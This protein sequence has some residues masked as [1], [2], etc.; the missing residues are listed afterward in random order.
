MLTF[1]KGMG[2]GPF[3]ERM[4]LGIGTLLRGGLEKRV[5]KDGVAGILGSRRGSHQDAAD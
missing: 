1:L 4:L 2:T 3:F 5:L